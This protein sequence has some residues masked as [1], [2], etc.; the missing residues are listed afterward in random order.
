MRRLRKCLRNFR[1]ELPGE[2]INIEL[3]LF[4]GIFMILKASDGA[5]N[6]VTFISDLCPTFISRDI[7]QPLVA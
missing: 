5:S 2:A 4:Y 6:K 1:D 3:Q 7:P